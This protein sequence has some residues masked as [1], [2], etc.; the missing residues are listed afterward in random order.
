MRAMDRKSAPEKVMAWSMVR[1]LA[2]QERVETMFPKT[3]TSKKK[4]TI[5]STLMR[6]VVYI[7]FI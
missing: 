5:S 4:T 2:K 1:L 6:S 7:T 3:V